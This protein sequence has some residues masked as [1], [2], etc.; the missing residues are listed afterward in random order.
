M[1]PKRLPRFEPKGF[2]KGMRKGWF[3]SPML[4]GLVQASWHLTAPNGL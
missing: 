1:G 2:G 4:S 3:R